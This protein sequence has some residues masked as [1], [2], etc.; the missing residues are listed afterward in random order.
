MNESMP[1]GSGSLTAADIE[2]SFHHGVKRGFRPSK[3]RKSLLMARIPHKGFS[4]SRNTAHVIIPRLELDPEGRNSPNSPR[5]SRPR[6]A[7]QLKWVSVSRSM[8]TCTL[9]GI[10][11]KP[12]PHL[13]LTGQKYIYPRWDLSYT[14]P[15]AR[16]REGCRRARSAPS[17]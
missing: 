3:V 12:S 10:L 14:V 5:L 15:G 1:G 2:V 4:F 16:S 11:D 13:T 9:L 17:C 6:T 7:S 8:R